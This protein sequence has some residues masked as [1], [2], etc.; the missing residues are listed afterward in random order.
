MRFEWQVASRALPIIA[1]FAAFCML[2]LSTTAAFSRPSKKSKKVTTAKAQPTLVCESPH[3]MPTLSGQTLS[4][5]HTIV[6]SW[7]A[8]V[9][10]PAHPSKALGYC[11]YKSPIEGDAKL[12]AKCTECELLTPQ[13]LT[14]TSCVDNAVAAGP[15]Y[16]YVVAAVNGGGMSGPSNETSASF[17]ANRPASSPLSGIPPCGGTNSPENNPA[18]K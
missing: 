8:T 14:G 10:S 18:R 1:A 7:N 9:P 2:F 4:A 12:E 17:Q 3:S 13:P 15:T 11:L 16:Y 6:L 5:R